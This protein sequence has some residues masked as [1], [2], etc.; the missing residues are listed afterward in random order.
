MEYSVTGDGGAIEFHSAG[1]PPT[2]YAETAEPLALR[3][4]D[5]YAAEIAYFIECCRTHTRPERCLPE[6][7][8]Y[9]VELMRELLA[10]R[11]RNGEKI[12]CSNQE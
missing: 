1:C 4:R 6:E 11:E 2:L 7:S 8:A 10:A 5:G 12:L 3:T 9:V